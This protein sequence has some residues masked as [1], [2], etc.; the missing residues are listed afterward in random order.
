MSL[1]SAAAHAPAKATNWKLILGLALAAAIAWLA[2]FDLAF[3]AATLGVPAVR[4]TAIILLALVGLRAGH[5]AG[6]AL[7]PPATVKRPILTPIAIAVVVAIGCAL[8][9][10]LFR[11]VLRPDYLR[12][13]VSEPVAA[14]TLLY[15]LRA[16]NEN[17][18]YRL[19][20]GSS[21][22]WLLGA[23]WRSPAGHPTKGAYWLGFAISQGLNVWINVTSQAAITPLAVLYDALRY[24]TP[25]MIWSWLYLR[26][27]FQSNEI[28]ST[29]VHL[30][31]QPLVTLLLR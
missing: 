20:L 19:F 27:G 25:G 8:A 26:R 28:A 2:P 4:A 16:F 21:L 3:K 24:F 22:A 13:M 6:L 12:A 14:R 7:E 5:A 1:I 23:V 18:M 17:I 30:F 29:T 31:F 11:P 10:R 15:G 9:D